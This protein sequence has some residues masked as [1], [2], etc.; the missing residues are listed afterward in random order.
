MNAVKEA[1]REMEEVLE[2]GEIPPWIKDIEFCHIS[3][4]GGNLFCGSQNDDG[5]PTCYPEYDGEALCPGCGNP[6]CP[7]CA[8]IAAL[9]ETLESTI[10][11]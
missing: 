6:T 7:R 10:V 2:E 9:E 3:D 11:D 4:E 1:I 5:G 8:Q